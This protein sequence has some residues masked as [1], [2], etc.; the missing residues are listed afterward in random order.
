MIIGVP[1]EIKN[2]E[3]R[4]ALTPE[5]A[6]ELSN[7]GHTILVQKGSGEGSGFSDNQYLNAG[8][9]I[10]KNAKEIFEDAEIIIKVKE[11][12]KIER[13]MIKDNQIIFT[14]LHL[15]ADKEL[16]LDLLKKK[17]IAIAYETIQLENGFLPI[18]APMSAVAGKLSV[19]IAANYL[20]TI[21]GGSGKLIG[22][23]P[24]VEPAKVLIIGGGIA[25]ANAAKVAIGM[26]AKVTIFDKDLNRMSYLSDI[27][28]EAVIRYSSDMAIDELI[29][30]TDILICSVYIPGN[31]APHLISRRHL[32]MMKPGSVIVDISIDQGG[33]CGTSRP[34]THSEPVFIENNII[35]YCVS[36]MPG[37]VPQTS[38]KALTCASL[39]FIIDIVNSGI[40][41]AAK[42]N[43]A[44]KR[45]IN[46][47]EG[48]ITNRGVAQAHN[49]EF[50]ELPF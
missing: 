39:P 12:L 11:P 23:L 1:K 7:L 32:K 33:C 10:I 42:K 26:G 15:A 45:G 37:A 34:T 49:L 40:V 43:Q 5:G 44:I 31:R 14:F 18:L 21:Y 25:G 17:I 4:V 50:S 29:P 46:I 3:K 24:G 19:Q 47:W 16:T 48:K 38:T 27:L 8:A 35:H 28:R 36:N 20:E 41:E 30:D 22:G 9:K 2:N 6:M 13:D